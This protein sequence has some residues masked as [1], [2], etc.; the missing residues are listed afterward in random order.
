[1]YVRG[2][3]ALLYNCLIVNN[4]AV[5]QGGGVFVEDGTVEMA[6][7]T[8]QGN[9]SEGA[10][11]VVNGGVALGERGWVDVRDSILWG[12]SGAQVGGISVRESGGSRA[13]V[14]YSAVKGIETTMF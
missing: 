2:G 13:R 9:R 10:G 12:N 4:V 14:E 6:R 3:A 11:G 7:V 5:Q 8:V 1:V